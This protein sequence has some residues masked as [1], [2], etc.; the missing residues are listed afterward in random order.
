MRVTKSGTI[1]Q[2]DCYPCGCTFVVGINCADTPDKG[3]NYYCRC[4]IC[5]NPCHASVND[6]K[7]IKPSMNDE[8]KIERKD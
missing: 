5:G 4:P 1:V 6:R 2:F 8:L 7:E 3:E